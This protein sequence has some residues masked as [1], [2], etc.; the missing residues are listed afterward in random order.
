MKQQ[1]IGELIELEVRKQGIPITRF[2]DM[3]NCQ[4]NNVYNIFERN[5]VDVRLLGKISKVLNRNFFEDVAEDMGLLKLEDPEIKKDMENKYAVAQFTEVVPE[6]LRKLGKIPTI[7]FGCPKDLMGEIVPDFIITEYL[8][9]FTIGESLLERFQRN[10][11]NEPHYLKHAEIT[12]EDGNTISVW[13]NLI[14]NEEFI[15][16][17]LDYKTEEEWEQILKFVFNKF[18][19]ND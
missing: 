10:G 2:A 9:T 17:K 15:D 3:I 7:S 19:P 14:S 6:V 16:I 11:I 4:R 1:S 13:K 12:D 5:S 8:I 18:Y